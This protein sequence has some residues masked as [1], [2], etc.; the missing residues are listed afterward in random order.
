MVYGLGEHFIA[1]YCAEYCGLR[2][3]HSIRHKTLCDPQS[4]V[5]ILYF[6]ARFKQVPKYR[7]DI[8]Y[9]PCSIYCHY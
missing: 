4:I 5:L 9:I 2:L 6:L 1:P 8:G 7:P 3:N